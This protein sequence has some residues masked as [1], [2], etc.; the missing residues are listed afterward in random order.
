MA[1]L[2][3][4]LLCEP[5][6]NKFPLAIAQMEEL[7]SFRQLGSMTPGHPENFVT[8]GVEVTT[9]PLGQ[10][11]CNAVGLALAE[12]NLAARFNKPDAPKIVDHYTYVLLAVVRCASRASFPQPMKGCRY[13][14]SSVLC[15]LPSL[16]C[17]YVTQQF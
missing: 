6:V 7:K 4:K 12:A 17:T 10:G 15:C 3:T 13:P 2:S 14:V 1:L 16:L 11:V 8:P 5:E 9:G